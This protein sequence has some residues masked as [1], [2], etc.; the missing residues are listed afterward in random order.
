MASPPTDEALRFS[1]EDEPGFEYH[2]LIQIIG[3]IQLVAEVLTILH[4]TYI[5]NIFIKVKT[6]HIHFRVLS[7]IFLFDL[8]L[9]ATT[10]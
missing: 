6:C 10:K 5:M 3:V 2:Y 9:K 1:N 7:C 4:V 8:I